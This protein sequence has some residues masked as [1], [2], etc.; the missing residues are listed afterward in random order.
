LAS[1][2]GFRKIKVTIGGVHQLRI[3]I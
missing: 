2:G 1:E 3:A